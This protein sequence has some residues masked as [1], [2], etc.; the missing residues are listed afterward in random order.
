MTSDFDRLQELWRRG[1]DF[2]GSEYAVMGGAT[3]WVSER[4]LVSAISEAGG[5]G[6]IA[7]GAMDPEL[8]G[9]EIAA[10]TPTSSERPASGRPPYS[11][12]SFSRTSTAAKGSV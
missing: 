1:C 9:A 7:C 6:V 4:N 12:T 5:F 2:F 3:S 10:T 11:G 8:L